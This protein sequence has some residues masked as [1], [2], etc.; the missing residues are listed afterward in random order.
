M[1]RYEKILLCKHQYMLLILAGLLALIASIVESIMPEMNFYVSCYL[2]II[3]VIICYGVISVFFLKKRNKGF[4]I[5]KS[6]D[7]LSA[8]AIALCV[9][10]VCYFFQN[11]IFNL[12][13]VFFDYIP[14]KYNYLVENITYENNSYSLIGRVVLIFSF[15][16]IIPFFEELFFRF[17]MLENYNNTSIILRFVLVN[18]C[19]VLLHDNIDL[20]IFVIPLSVVCSLL[21]HNKRCFVY[22]FIVHCIVNIVGILEI[23]LDEIAFSPKYAIQYSEK[24]TALTNVFF[25]IIVVAFFTTLLCAIMGQKKEDSINEGVLVKNRDNL[26]YFFSVGIYFL[27]QYLAG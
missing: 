16:I 25:N 11:M 1:K 24:T 9:A 19:F 10:L 5:M 3:N 4:F 18:F 13:Y 26:S 14:E 17:V 15:G 21:M 27:L 6:K 2:S 8:S 12:L 7:I 22:P 23:P 20:M